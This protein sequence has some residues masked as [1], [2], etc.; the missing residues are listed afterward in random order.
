MGMNVGGGPGGIKSEIN[1]TPLVDVVLVLLI[2]FM[3]VM[4]ELQKGKNISLP[5]AENV[6]REERGTPLILSLT[7]DKKMYVEDEHCA[8]ALA[9]RVQLREVLNKQP[10]RRILLKADQTLDFG[11]V[12]EVMELARAAGAKGVAVAVVQSSD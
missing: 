5:K 11:A 7:Q 6:T 3:V 1:V 10:S 9:L 2:I 8:D 12:R 4:P